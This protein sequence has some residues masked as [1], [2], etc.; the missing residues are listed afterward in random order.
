MGLAALC[1]GCGGDD[2]PQRASGGPIAPP[3]ERAT[4]ALGRT[5]LPKVLVQVPVFNEPAVVERAIDAV[6]ALD[7]PLDRLQI[8]ILDDSTDETTRLAR[9]RARFHRE[10]GVHIDVVRRPDR[11]SFK[12]GALAAG[13]AR[14]RGEYIAVFDADFQPR[15][16]FLL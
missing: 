14:A 7:Y 12:A 15:P 2:G 1:L 11:S 8:Q 3:A 4:A 6:A 5:V 16:D 13:L 10:R 9:A